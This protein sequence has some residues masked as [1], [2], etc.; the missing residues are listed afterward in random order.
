MTTNQA[1]VPP[2]RSLFTNQLDGS[3]P[4]LPPFPSND[5]IPT[6]P[7]FGF[8]SAPMEVSLRRGRAIK[9]HLFSHFPRPSTDGLALANFF[10]F[11]CSIAAKLVDSP[12][13]S[14]QADGIR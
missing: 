9:T 14:D 6:V 2:L 4:L 10:P 3:G 7:P 13:L 1:C 5:S 8:P 12:C 11:A